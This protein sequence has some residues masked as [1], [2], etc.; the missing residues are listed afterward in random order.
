MRHAQTEF[1]GCFVDVGPA[2]TPDD[3]PYIE[4]YFDAIAKRLPTRL[5]GFTG[6]NS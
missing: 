5:P 2:Y 3:R 6:S 4:R 1:I